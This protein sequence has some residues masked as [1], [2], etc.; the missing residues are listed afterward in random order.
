ML[1]I[2]CSL[3][4]TSV[5]IVRKC[6]HLRKK[7]RKCYANLVGVSCSISDDW[8]SKNAILLFLYL[9]L[10]KILFTRSLTALERIN[11]TEQLMSYALLQMLTLFIT[12]VV[13]LRC[14]LPL[15]G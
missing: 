10:G 7:V 4:A 5:I 14:S 13:G 11:V 15:Q 12:L 3:A 6:E 2:L 9:F 8:M 1:G